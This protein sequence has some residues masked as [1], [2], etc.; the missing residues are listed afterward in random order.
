MPINKNDIAKL[1]KNVF[2]KYIA[3]SPII[4]IEAVKK[5][6]FF[7]F[8]G[9]VILLIKIYFC[10]I[11]SCPAPTKHPAP[12]EIGV[13]P[14]APTNPPATQLPTTD[15]QLVLPP[16]ISIISWFVNNLI[17]AVFIFISSLLS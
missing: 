11:Q 13:P 2:E 9:I 15:P 8:F 10:E 17:F 3:V 7:S 5:R 14:N 16:K 12:I 1:F 4:A 6:S